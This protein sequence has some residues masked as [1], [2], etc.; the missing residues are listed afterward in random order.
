MRLLIHTL[1]SAAVGIR[2]Y[3][4]NHIVK[5]IMDEIAYSCQN[6]PTCR[7]VL[8]GEYLDLKWRHMNAIASPI[9]WLSTVCKTAY[10]GLKQRNY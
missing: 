6:I 5:Q 7:T 10:C 8:F 3:V 9:T 1:S 4:S 2:V